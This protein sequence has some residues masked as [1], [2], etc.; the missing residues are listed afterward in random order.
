MQEGGVTISTS[1]LIFFGLMQILF[2]SNLFP[3]TTE[4]WRGLDNATLLQ[5]LRRERPDLKVHALALRP[6]LLPRS[7][8]LEARA[9]D[10]WTTPEY[11]AVP[12]LPKAGG[13]NDR[14]VSMALSRRIAARI[15]K[16]AFDVILT[17]WLFPDACGIHRAL[18]RQASRQ[19]AIAQ[20][21]DVHR[22]LKMPMRRRAI[23]RMG[24]TVG[25]IIT[26]SKDLGGR[27]TAAGVS[28]SKVHPVYN[29]VDTEC[30]H[31]GARS[32][33]RAE[34]RLPENARVA[35]FVGNFLPVKGIDLLLR[36]IAEAGRR[37]SAIHLVLIG[38]GPLEKDLRHLA[39]ELGISDRLHW[40]GRLPPTGV[41]QYMR[42]ADVVCLS[43]HNEGLP[44]VV[45]EALACGRPVISTD[46]GGIH[47]V[48]GRDNTIHSLISGRSA[49]D[50]ASALVRLV[51]DESNAD[52]ISR[53]GSNYS[54]QNCARHHL[55]IMA[56]LKETSPPS[57][58]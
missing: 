39:G 15:E 44:N 33:I 26:R 13:M 58:P 10:E 48:L 29:G 1:A 9:C 18:G 47:E 45:L 36:G 37:G 56:G 28:S 12:Y 21:S 19:V 46:V 14:L 11:L 32:P 55:Q 5:A 43:S 53:A 52:E 51:S 3:D 24:G 34:L 8:R 23:V 25:A 22:Y 16:T 4:P 7:L 20:G 57:P 50:Y 6:R 54:W 30:F 2:I 31:P 35:V 42:A 17:P 27:L 41:A 49:D 38:S 40:P